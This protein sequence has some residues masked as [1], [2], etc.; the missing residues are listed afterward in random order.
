MSELCY[1]SATDA[2]ASFRAR[3]LSPVELVRALIAR[4]ELV[5]PHVRAFTYTFDDRALAAALAAEERYAAGTARPLEGIP[6][7][8]KDVLGS[9]PHTT[10]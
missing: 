6:I 3:R 2:I 4:R 10:V 1:L 5:E 9:I 8:I 7:G